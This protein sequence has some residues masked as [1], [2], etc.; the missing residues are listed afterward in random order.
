M[1]PKIKSR[2][3]SD[4]IYTYRRVCVYNSHTGLGIVSHY[5]T[6]MSRA[7]SDTSMN[8]AAMFHTSHRW[9]GYRIKVC[10]KYVS[11]DLVQIRVKCGVSEW[12]KRNTLKWLGHIERKESKEFV[13]KVYVSENEGSRKASC[14]MDGCG[15]GIHA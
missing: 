12:V 4:L 1:K 13:K 14:K 5:P 9:E 3:T 15:K 6:Q 10:M 2:N 11:W 8:K 7:H